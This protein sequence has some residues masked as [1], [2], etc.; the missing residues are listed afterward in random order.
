MFRPGAPIDEIE[1]DVE[2][3]IVELVHELGTL[4]DADPIERGADERAYIKVFSDV[5][6]NSGRDQAALLTAAVNRPNLAESLL[7]L[8][9]WLDGAARADREPSR[10]MR[11]LVRLAMDGLWV[12]DILDPTR[13]TSAQR[14]RLTE[15]LQALTYLTDGEVVE[16]A[17]GQRAGRGEPERQAATL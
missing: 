15:I 12:S 7:Y 3:I 14:D 16:L 2:S 8:N 10:A 9:R 17:S 1:R 4:A 11:M 13:F 5:Y 6:K